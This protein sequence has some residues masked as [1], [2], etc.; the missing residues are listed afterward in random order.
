MDVVYC[1]NKN[2]SPQ[3]LYTLTLI[4]D[5]SPAHS[6]HRLLSANFDIDG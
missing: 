1:N 6:S 3:D 2:S 4:S 5:A